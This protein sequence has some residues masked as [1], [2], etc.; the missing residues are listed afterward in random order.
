M[1]SAFALRHGPFRKPALLLTAVLALWSAAGTAQASAAADPFPPAP[2][3]ARTARP[4]SSTFFG[5]TVNKLGTHQSWPALGTR[6]V[7]LWDTHTRWM[8]IEPAKGRWDFTRPDMYVDYAQRHGAQVLFTLGQTPAWAA[9]DAKVHCYYA[10][11]CS[12]P[13]DLADWRT[14]VGTLAAR[15]GSRVRYWELWNEPNTPEFWRGSPE[16]LAEMA[17]IAREEILRANPNAQFLGPGLGAVGFGFLDRFLTAG[18]GDSLDA[19]SFHA[20]ANASVRQVIASQSRVRAIADRHGKAGLPLWNTEFGISCGPQ[21]AHC[22]DR[23]GAATEAALQ[24]VLA[25]LFVMAAEG[26]QNV[27]F[28]FQE[29]GLPQAPFSLTAPPDYLALTPA[30]QAYAR[31]VGL[32]DGAF[33]TESYDDRGVLVVRFNNR[34]RNYVALWSEGRAATLRIPATWRFTRYQVLSSGRAISRARDGSLLLPGSTL[35]VGSS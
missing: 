11:G 16:Q 27:D 1:S 12:P 7:R 34:G 26:V 29:R 35:V 24:R 30:G 33:V 5:M 23:S 14:Y 15:Y 6:I 9:A 20:Y 21:A 4:V 31:V 28:Y 25:S 18:G 3:S 19:I 13:A 17:R 10:A 22:E 32:L 2:Q 8:D